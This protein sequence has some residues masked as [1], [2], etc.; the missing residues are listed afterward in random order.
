MQHRVKKKQLAAASNRI[1]EMDRWRQTLPPSFLSLDE[2]PLWAERFSWL[3]LISVGEGLVRA[4][5]R[6]RA[7]LQR[8]ATCV[9]VCICVCLLHRYR[10]KHVVGQC[11]AC[12]E[13]SACAP[14]K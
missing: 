1:R 9:S 2:L 4:G 14:I 6:G 13:V 3:G 8:V 7:G 10:D 5:G 11:L 12:R